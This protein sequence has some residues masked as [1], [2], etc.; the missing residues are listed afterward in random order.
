[1]AATLEVSM[2]GFK[3]LLPPPPSP[4]PVPSRLCTA[5]WGRGIFAII[6]FTFFP[7]M[8]VSV[9]SCLWKPEEG[10]GSSEAGV[11][12]SGGGETQH[13]CWELN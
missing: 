11:T 4:P 3:R 2:Q 9:L 8:C 10:V 6:V 7:L 12:G 13:G 5:L 1:M